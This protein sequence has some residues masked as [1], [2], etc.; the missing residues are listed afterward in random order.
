MVPCHESAVQL[1]A[2]PPLD[3]DGNTP[4]TGNGATCSDFFNSI[5][6]PTPHSPSQKSRSAAG[7]DPLEKSA[8]THFHSLGK[9]LWGQGGC[10]GKYRE[11]SSRVLPSHQGK[12]L[13][14]A[15]EVGST[16]GEAKF[17][18][19]A[20]GSREALKRGPGGAG[21]V[22]T[23]STSAESFDEGFV[24]HL[25][26]GSFAESLLAAGSTSAAPHSK[27][28][29][30]SAA[31]MKALA[32]KEG[33][34]PYSLKGSLEEQQGGGKRE[35]QDTA[36]AEVYPLFFPPGLL[37]HASSS[38]SSS[39]GLS[40]VSGEC[41]EGV[42]GGAGGRVQG[43]QVHGPPG[44][45]VFIFHI[46]NEWTEQDLLTHFNVYGPVVS[47]RI[48][49]DRVSGRNRGFGFVSFSSVQAAGAAVMAMN[50][51]QVRESK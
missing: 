19:D 21:V 15:E 12:K 1:L 8:S 6:P 44:A 46:P 23:Q 16:G 14:T 31:A 36:P 10:S 51:F 27:T 24:G 41:R 7:G 20:A 9:I 33:D 29:T 40:G 18:F 22:R 5:L 2:H 42:A 3:S 28:T 4:N 35:E 11:A 38:S 13:H 48:A 49:S 32:E 50:G 39:A 17:P 25:L 37:S 43:S 30:R 47:A 45:N 34:K 26:G